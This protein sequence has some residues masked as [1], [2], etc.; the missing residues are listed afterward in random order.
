MISFELFVGAG[1]LALGISDAGFK[2]EG[3]IE[4]D[5]NA[6]DTIRLNQERGI[7]P[8]R[9]WQLYQTDVRLFNFNK[10]S[11]IIDLL[12]GGP[13]CQPFS[14]GGKHRGYFDKRDMFPEMVR[15]VRE[16]CPKIVLVE[17]VRGLVR[18][19]F[20][21]YFEY[22][23]LQFTY[24]EIIRLDNENWP[25]HLSRL[26]CYHMKGNC[27]GL[28][29]RVVYRVLNAA[30][31]GVPQ[32]RERVFI[33]GVRND[34]HMAWSFPKPTHSHEA[35]LWRQW[36]T[37]EYWERHRVAKK[38]RPA[39]PSKLKEK[40][41]MLNGKIFTP[42]EQPW[43]TVRDA[44]SD[45]PDPEDTRKADTTI[46]NHEFRPGARQ[47][48][49]HTGSPLDEPSKTLKAG[50]HGVP[51][52]ENMLLRPEGCVR[53]FTV[54]ES[55]RLQTFPDN[56]VFPG[57]WTESMRQLGNAVPVKLA[58]FLTQNLR[59]HLQNLSL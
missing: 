15:A 28:S 47:Y 57:S 55:A 41:N 4:W 51:G 54:R 35:L 12:A 16:T 29:Y 50:D 59:S 1:G 24:P 22:I 42:L 25:D 40:I 6:C 13:P 36:I 31:Y 20:S 8:V 46:P 53:Y 38:Q 21:K 37:E 3:V 14:I 56:Y 43:R 30:D 39:I 44:I 23:I 26:E 18:K 52:G 7:E 48:P 19:S 34:I 5:S 32:K 9:D 49:G 2:H 33:V 27:D 11:G 58:S 45:L 10:Y 17:N